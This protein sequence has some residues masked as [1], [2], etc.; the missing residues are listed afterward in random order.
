MGEVV[1]HD[2]LFAL[3]GREWMDAQFGRTPSHQA[4]S[5]NVDRAIAAAVTK[6]DRVHLNPARPR[7]AGVR[8]S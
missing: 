3:I 5:A 8:H 7:H 1:R 2:E 4:F 6:R